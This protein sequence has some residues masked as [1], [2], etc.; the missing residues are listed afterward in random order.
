[1]SQFVARAWKDQSSFWRDHPAY[2]NLRAHLM[3]SQSSME[4]MD[5]L[6]AILAEFN[7]YVKRGTLVT[8][9]QIIFEFA[10]EED[11]MKFVLVWS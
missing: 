5:Q 4:Y 8:T 2:D 6:N 7:G 11:L 1:M 10:T 9:N 3:E